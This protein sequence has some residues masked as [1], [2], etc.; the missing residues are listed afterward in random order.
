MRAAGQR[1]A[2]TPGRGDTGVFAGAAADAGRRGGPGRPRGTEPDNAVEATRHGVA[3]T[4]HSPGGH[5]PW[6]AAAAGKRPPSGPLAAH[7]AAG[8]GGAAAS[9]VMRVAFATT[10]LV[11]VDAHFGTA[12]CFLL[13]DVG[14]GGAGPLA[15]I[16]FAAGDEDGDHGKLGPRLGALEGCTLVFA[17]AVGPSAAA[18]LAARG[19][20][21]APSRPGERIDELLVRLARLLAG[22]PPPWLRRALGRSPSAAEAAAATGGA[23]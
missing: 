11:T 8:T 10:D 20:R 6:R 21:A 23:T 2:G 22:T 14:A 12:P 4:R 18:Q 17:A 19:V 13:C 5:G 16:R 7:P 1:G 9:D 15:E 3:G